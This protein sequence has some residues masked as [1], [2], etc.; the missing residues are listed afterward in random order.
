[1]GKALVPAVPR[2]FS[3]LGHPTKYIVTIE[4]FHTALLFMSANKDLNYNKEGVQNGT[5]FLNFF[6][7]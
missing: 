1:M 6:K 4:K 5:R 2:L 7:T 3:H